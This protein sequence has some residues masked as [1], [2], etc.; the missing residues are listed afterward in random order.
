MQAAARSLNARKELAASR[1]AATTMQAAA[2]A[3]RCR[4]ELSAS[5]GAAI[6][7]ET[8]ARAL[9]C[10]RELAAS[11]SAATKL[12]AAVRRH[13]AAQHYA[14]QRAAVTAL[15]ASVRSLP[16]R[17][18]LAASRSAATVVQ[19]V[20]RRNTC[21]AQYQR[22]RWAS[23]RLATAARGKAARTHVENYR[24]A[25]NAAA[26]ALQAAQRR[27]LRRRESAARVIQAEARR[28]LLPRLIR[29]KRLMNE[30]AIDDFF[31]N[32]KL[33]PRPP[34]QKRT[35]AR[36]TGRSAPGE[37]ASA[38]IQ[39]AP[40]TTRKA[41]FCSQCGTPVTP[42]A[43][44]CAS[45]GHKLN[46][47]GN[48]E[49]AGGAR[50]RSLPAHRGSGGKVRPVDTVDKVPKSLGLP[51]HQKGTLTRAGVPPS[52]RMRGGVATAA[53]AAGD[54]QTRPASLPTDRGGPELHESPRSHIRTKDPSM[55]WDTYVARRGGPSDGLQL[56]PLPTPVLGSVLRPRRAFAGTYW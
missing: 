23:T 50:S 52:Y 21:A 37:R 54:A 51:L 47:E 7:I 12:Q 15:Q 8:A 27:R 46:A 42:G 40:P 3:I 18:N 56:P 30:R 36:R 33:S 49:R 48:S 55:G 19:A 34:Q 14:Q 9:R 5:R 26:R 41:A 35:T 29:R 1:E 22:R 16:C 6:K 45:C 10:R 17:R 13:A 32:V 38:P 20:A 31:M 4:K 43:R 53:D 25:A 28:R 2:R 39:T 24:R 11:R 44:F